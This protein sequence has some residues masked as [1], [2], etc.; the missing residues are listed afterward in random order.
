MTPPTGFDTDHI[1]AIAGVIRVSYVGDIQD[2]S[3]K[4]E[5]GLAMHDET[6]FTNVVVVGQQDMKKTWLYK[7]Y[8]VVAGVRC[9]YFPINQ[10][11]LEDFTSASLHKVAYHIAISGANPDAN[12]IRVDYEFYFEGTPDY[13]VFNQY[14]PKMGETSATLGQDVASV[15]SLVLKNA[16]VTNLAE[17]S[18]SESFMSTVIGSL[19]SGAKMLMPHVPALLELLM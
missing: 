9:I 13:T 3:G 15:S 1:Q 4:L 11:Q 17:E 14:L 10:S 19:I 2:V 7:C 18:N 12:S 8:P 16:A 6:G 5:V